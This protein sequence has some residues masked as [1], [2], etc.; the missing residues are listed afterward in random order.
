MFGMNRDDVLESNYFSAQF[1]VRTF[2]KYLLQIPRNERY[3]TA[4]QWFENLRNTVT[5]SMTGDN[6]IAIDMENKRKE[7]IIDEKLEAFIDKYGCTIGL[8][9]YSLSCTTKEFAVILKR[10]RILDCFTTTYNPTILKAFNSRLEISQLHSEAAWLKFDGKYSPS[11]P[12][13][14]DTELSEL[15]ET[16]SLVSLAEFYSLSDPK[17]VMDIVS[18]PVV[19]ISTYEN[20]KPKFK[21]DSIVMFLPRKCKFQ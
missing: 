21:K 14:E 13:L 5:V 19:F 7:F 16:H 2:K 20:L 8:Y 12:N 11:L 3:I 6:M 10:R 15:G 4:N 1:L 17:K 18:V 9:H